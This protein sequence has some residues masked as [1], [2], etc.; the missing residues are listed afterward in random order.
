MRQ[1]KIIILSILCLLLTDNL[2]ARSPLRRPDKTT[3]YITTQWEGEKKV[4]LL[5]DSHLELFP[6]FEIYDPLHIQ[7][8]ILPKTSI[9]FRNNS[10]K[11]VKGTVINNLIEHLLKEISQGKTKYKDFIILKNRDFNIKKQA[12][13]LIVKSK[14]YPFVVKLFMETPHSFIRPYNKGFEPACIFLIG[15]GATRHMLGFTR[16]K[17]AHFIKKRIEKNH[18]WKNC[19]DLPRKWFWFPQNQKMIT[20]TGYNIGG[21]KKI[22]K[23]IPST[24]AIVV[25]AINEE[26]TFSFFSPEDRR[27]AIDLSNFL[28]C[29]IDPHINNFMIEKET[30]KILLIDTEH[31]PSLAGFKERPRITTYSSWY[32]HLLFKYVKD[33]FFR[34]KNER[35]SLQKNPRQPFLIP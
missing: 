5:R 4:H 8:N 7:K 18:H 20:L 32:L 28:L 15:G 12:G 23:K 21:Y 33:R 2:L 10:K 27:T 35:V 3:P 11:S 19:V 9:S 29:C 34:S 17:N 13:L 6:L 24:Y 25:D 1:K 31:F 30:G 22:A 16:I 26:R 14:E